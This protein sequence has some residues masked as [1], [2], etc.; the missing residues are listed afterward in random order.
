MPPSLVDEYLKITDEYRK[1]YGPKTIVWMQT[2]SFYEVYAWNECDE[3]IKV[4]RDIL[5][6]RLTKKGGSRNM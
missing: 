6:I 3:Q 2:G 4:S 1:R 5:Q